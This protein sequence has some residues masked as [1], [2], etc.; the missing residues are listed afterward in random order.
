MIDTKYK[1]HINPFEDTE[2]TEVL[3]F[4]ELPVLYVETD[5][6][7]SLYLSYL[8]RFVDED[9]EQRLVI[10]ISGKRLGEVRKGLISVRSAFESPETGFVFII[11]LNQTDGKAGNIYLLPN[12]VFQRYN[13]ID[14]DYYISGE[15]NGDREDE[16][17]VIPLSCYDFK[18]PAV[19][20][21][22][23]KSARLRTKPDQMPLQIS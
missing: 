3:D 7:D 2:V 10:K 16:N 23:N 19:N 13:R 22:L 18:S 12:E 8:D 21:Y 11:H 9:T 4:E 6:S 15:E 20:N 17:I 5:M 14:R 1:I